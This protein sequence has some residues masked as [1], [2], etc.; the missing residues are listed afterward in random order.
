MIADRIIF[1]NKLLADAAAEPEDRRRLL[2]RWA[3]YSGRPWETVRQQ[4][5]SATQAVPADKRRRVL[6]PLWSDDDKQVTVAAGVIFLAKV[7]MNY[8]WAVEHEPTV[9]GVTPDLRIRKGQAD[10]LVEARHV[11]GEL[12]LPVGFQRLKAA[13]RPIRTRTPAEFTCIEVDARAPLR[14]FR[15]FLR[16]ALRENRPGPQVYE[17]TGVRIAYQLLPELPNEVGAFFSYVPDATWFDDGPAVRAA[18][19]EK[20]KKY[21]FPLVVAL[22]GVDT[23]DLFSAA[24]EAPYGTE[25]VRIP[26][27]HKTGGPAGLATLARRPESVAGRAGSDAERVRTRLEALLPFEVVG[28]ERGFAIRARVLSNPAKPSV[29]G[30]QEFQHNPLNS[31][32]PRTLSG[33]PSVGSVRMPLGP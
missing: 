21:P 26:I 18:L 28:T 24:E 15:A 10:F 32:R 29:A 16:K 27:S 8:G 13:I 3:M 6:G 9:S 7:L 14:G 23:G 5:E 30:L 22:Q 31:Q 2:F 25:V 1:S 12:G 20:L 17:E 33:N 4:L 19:D 11:V